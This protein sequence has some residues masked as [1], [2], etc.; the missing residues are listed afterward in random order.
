MSSEWKGLGFMKNKVFLLAKIQ[1]SAL[2][3]D[4]V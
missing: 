4:T 1:L 2:D 3:Y